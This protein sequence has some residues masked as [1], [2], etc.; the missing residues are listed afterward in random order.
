MTR[1]GESGLREILPNDLSAELERVLLPRLAGH[2]RARSAGHCMRVA[3]QQSSRSQCRGHR[4]AKI[5]NLHL[6]PFRHSPGLV[7]DYRNTKLDREI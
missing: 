6:I 4:F 2:L 5:H 3:D 7:R 1:F